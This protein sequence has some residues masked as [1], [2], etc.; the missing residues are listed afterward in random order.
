MEFE[1]QEKLYFGQFINYSVLSLLLGAVIECQSAAEMNWMW[2]GTH[3][4]TVFWAV[5]TFAVYE[6][7]ERP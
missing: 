4:N 7:L 6:V 1:T 3:S 2:I 5:D